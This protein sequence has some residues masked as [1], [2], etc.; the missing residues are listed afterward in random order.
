MLGLRSP[1]APASTVWLS[2]PPTPSP[3]VSPH[4]HLSLPPFLFLR[5]SPAHSQSS[6]LTFLNYRPAPL[7]LVLS[8]CFSGSFLLGKSLFAANVTF[9]EGRSFP[10]SCRPHG[11]GLGCRLW[12]PHHSCSSPEAPLMFTP[13]SS[14]L[15]SP[16]SPCPPF[17]RVSTHTTI[18]QLLEECFAQACA[19]AEHAA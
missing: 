7:C 2:T 10:S 18:V 17:F 12:G 1:A 13:A 16:A 19:L 15:L 14:F 11:P 5:P 8:V 4:L 6:C 9:H 3:P